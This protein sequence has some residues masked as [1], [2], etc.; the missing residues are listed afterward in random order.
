M[1][2]ST[3]VRLVFA[4]NV[5]SNSN[6][7]FEMS[8]GEKKTFSSLSTMTILY[9]E[10]CPLVLRGKVIWLKVCFHKHDALDEN[11]LGDFF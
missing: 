8:A 2:E 10:L 11:R 5:V 4:N 3:A 1:F 7:K 9:F 6:C